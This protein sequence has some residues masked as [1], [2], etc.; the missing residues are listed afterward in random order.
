MINA[1]PKVLQINADNRRTPFVAVALAEVPVIE[2]PPCRMLD[3]ALEL[4][5]LSDELFVAPTPGDLD[6]IAAQADLLGVPPPTRDPMLA[7]TA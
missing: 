7:A 3:A 4:V 5:A 6:A 1:A 2:A